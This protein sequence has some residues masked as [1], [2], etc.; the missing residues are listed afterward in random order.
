MPCGLSA[1][2][3]AVTITT[4]TP[5]TVL[6]GIIN[7]F[8]DADMPDAFRGNVIGAG[9]ASVYIHGSANVLVGAGCTS[10]T[11]KCF[12]NAGV[13]VGLAKTVSVTAGNTAEI[14]FHFKDTAPRTNNAYS[15][16]LTC[17]AATANSTVND[18][19]ASAD[20]PG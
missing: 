2:A 20:M 13:Q 6:S 5:T 12:N 17:N 3:T 1:E 19:L 4:T 9:N 7:S 14:S 18:V 8:D 10:I 16:Q 11:A 15:L